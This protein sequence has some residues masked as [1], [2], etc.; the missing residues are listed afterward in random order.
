MTTSSRASDDTTLD[1]P[2]ALRAKAD[3]DAV[4]A[5]LSGILDTVDLPIVLIGRDC[6]VTRFNRAA[7]TALGF[8]PDDLRRP[9]GDIRLP[10]DMPDLQSHCTRVI[11][12]GVPI[13]REVRDAERWFLLRIA[14]YRGSDHQ[15]HGAVLT[16]N[17][18]TAFRASVEQA[19]Y[20]REYTK[21][22]LN[23]IIEPLVVIDA[24]LRLQTAN[25]AFYTTFQI[26]REEA[27]GIP[28]PALRNQDWTHSSLWDLLRQALSEG[29]EFQTLEIEHAFPV[30]G[31]RV[32]LVDA[33]PLSRE[34]GRSPLML[35][36]FRDFTQRRRIEQELRE[37]VRAKDEFLATL[38]HELRGPLA[39]LR[40]ML[41]IQKRADGNPRLIQQA[42]STMDRQLSQLTRL[43][44]DL[45]DMSRIH[46]GRIELKRERITLESAV[47]HAVEACRPFAE[48]ARHELDISLPSEPI[49]L[50]ADPARVAQIL[51]N[52]LSNACKYTEGGG[53]ISLRAE[54]VPGSHPTVVVRIKDTGIGIPS[55]RIEN[56]FELFTQIDRTP[57]RSQGGLGIGLTLVKRLV[58]MHGGT[59]EASSEG[60]GRGSEFVV[61]LPALIDPSIDSSSSQPSARESI[62]LPRRILVVDDNRDSAES[63]AM[64]LDLEGNETCT[65]HDGM[66]A[67]ETAER[68]RPDVVLLDIGL[69]RLSGYE[70][71]RRIRAESWGKDIVL[72]ALTGWGQQ[73]DRRQSQDAGFDAHLV[74]PVNYELLMKLLASRPPTHRTIQ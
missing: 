60:V 64:L 42:C 58:E 17:N 37:S 45:L 7:E 53:H 34:E 40:H 15:I 48:S 46:W 6:T 66:E 54:V 11:A 8:R 62:P 22:I 35:L 3:A 44:D 21:A 55:D 72:V 41:E 57:H 52:L 31:R 30:I 16:F 68:F 61:R 2:D 43:V 9:L 27:Q 24:D 12:D 25:R 33:R 1:A 71:A 4:N 38:S 10:V 51:G 69:P 65:A 73:E 23:T 20:E 50:D 13:R 29:K 70:A 74:K 63:L 49:Y 19:L 32:L 56:I 47:F 36:A 59:V 67:V 26:A 18:V 39:P 14:P 28:L 5:D